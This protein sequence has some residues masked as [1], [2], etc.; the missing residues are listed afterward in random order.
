[1]SFSYGDTE[2]LCVVSEYNPDVILHFGT[3]EMCYS[4]LRKHI[5]KTNRKRLALCSTITK[6]GKVIPYRYVSWILK[7]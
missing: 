6:E 7:D 2:F 1:M 4:Y 3:Q 5:G